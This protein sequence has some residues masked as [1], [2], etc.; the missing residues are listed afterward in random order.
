MIAD[1]V[2]AVVVARTSLTAKSRLSPILSPEQRSR[3]AEAMLAD[4]LAACEAAGLAGTIAVVSA[5]GEPD[6]TRLGAVRLVLDPGEGLNPAVA[7]GVLAATQAGA[8]AVLVLPADIPL[9]RAE[10]LFA[11]LA[12]AGQAPR[13]VVL[14]TDRAGEG[15]NAL[16]VR[17]PRLTQPSF[18]PASAAR[19]LEAGRQAGALVVAVDR[20]ALALDID[21]PGDLDALRQS[22][23]G[24]A[25]G[26]LL[27]E[28]MGAGAAP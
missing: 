25:T 13:A 4:V 5:A 27:A 23:P 10:D 8:S 11:V 18:G 7:A 22:Q 16:L 19:H 28:L 24:G 2:W 20:P 15:T 9:A 17:P 14:A 21:T 1:G 12:A 6:A 26:L 3:L